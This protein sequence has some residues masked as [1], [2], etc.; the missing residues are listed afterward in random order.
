MYF[1]PRKL[2]DNSNSIAFSA[3]AALAALA[4][5]DVLEYE[6]NKP[7]PFV[8]LGGCNGD[9]D[10]EEQLKLLLALLLLLPVLLREPPEFRL[11]NNEDEDDDIEVI[12]RVV[13]V[14]VVTYLTSWTGSILAS[15]TLIST[16]STD[17]L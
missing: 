16:S 14:V 5:E 10:G 2:I 9:D 7:T 1:R 3:A 15:V 6:D 8:V 11:L 4:L 17:W 12:L 13:D